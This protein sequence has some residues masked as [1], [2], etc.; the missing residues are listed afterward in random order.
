MR[1][2]F[3]RFKGFLSFCATIITKIN[4]AYS[5]IRKVSLAIIIYNP[6][7]QL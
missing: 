7:E 2:M 1:E 3:F 6:K 5:K 4:Y